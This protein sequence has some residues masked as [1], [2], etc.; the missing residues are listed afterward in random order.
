MAA[1]LFVGNLSFRA[2][3]EGLKQLFAQAGTVVSA[4]LVTD[5]QTGRPRGFG[6]VE[7]ATDEEAARAIQMLNGKMFMER[8]LTVSEAKSQSA[9]GSPRG[10]RP[11]GGGGG[12]MGR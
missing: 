7:M 12:G 9:P 8:P 5:S 6:F 1:K 11:G 10:G 2:S 3:E 4:K